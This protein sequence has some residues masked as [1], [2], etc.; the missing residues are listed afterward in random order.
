MS[1]KFHQLYVVRCEMGD[2]AVR[3]AEFERASEV[4]KNQKAAIERAWEI[5]PKATPLV[6]RVRNTTRGLPNK[7][8]KP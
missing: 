4:A 3:C 2:Y 7:W 1:N 8:C 6:E 5:D